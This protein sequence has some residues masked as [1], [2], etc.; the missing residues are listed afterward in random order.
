MSG[1]LA[2]FLGHFPDAMKYPTKRLLFH[3]PD[4]VLGG[5]PYT[6]VGRVE[7]H[8]IRTFPIYCGTA[9]VAFDRACPYT[10]SVLFWGSHIVYGV[11]LKLLLLLLLLL[12]LSLLLLV[13]TPSPPPPLLT[14][15]LA[16]RV[17]RAHHLVKSTLCCI[18]VFRNKVTFFN[19]SYDCRA[20]TLNLFPVIIICRKFE[21]KVFQV[22]FFWLMSFRRLLRH[23]G[24]T[25]WVICL[26][27]DFI[28]RTFYSRSVCFGHCFPRSFSNNNNNNNNNNNINNNNN[29]NNNINIYSRGGALFWPFWLRE[30]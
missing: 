29:N 3:S 24:W 2:P 20:I 26:A 27:I 9:V 22:P 18:W 5:S 6:T 14:L 8:W 30:V 17:R 1:L 7:I 11:L 19:V 4:T 12:L 15:L 10:A 23:R 21:L 25:S 28:R 13:W 16:K